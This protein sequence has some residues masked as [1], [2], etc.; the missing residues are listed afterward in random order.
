MKQ[1]YCFLMQKNLLAALI[2]D[3][4]QKVLPK[5]HA[6]PFTPLAMTLSTE[7]GLTVTISTFLSIYSWHGVF[8]KATYN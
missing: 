5:A 7:H 1:Y 3:P 4:L 8:T 6:C 2:C